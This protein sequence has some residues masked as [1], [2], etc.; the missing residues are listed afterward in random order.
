V[1]ATTRAAWLLS[2]NR[3]NSADIQVFLRGGSVESTVIFD[4]MRIRAGDNFGVVV[5]FVNELDEVVSPSAQFVRCS[6]RDSLN[7]EL[8]AFA[9]SSVL[10]STPVPH[11]ELQF[12]IDALAGEALGLLDTQAKD[13]PVVIDVEWV[14][15]GNTHSSQTIPGVVEFGLTPQVP[16]VV[17]GD[18]GS[19]TGGDTGGGDTGGGDTGG[20]GGGDTG[21]GDTG[22]GDTAVLNII[23]DFLTGLAPQNGTFVLAIVDGRLKVL[24]TDEC[25]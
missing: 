3:W 16:A 22:G 13:L 20:G 25:S 21:G 24:P 9:E 10:E 1:S 19:G 12:D 18:I 2:E 14:V 7:R 17:S 5:M 8:L 23:D 6:V 11:Y 4:R 15:G